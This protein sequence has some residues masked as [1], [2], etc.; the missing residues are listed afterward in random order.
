MQYALLNN[1]RIPATKSKEIAYC[2]CCNSEV[3]AYC[4]DIMVWHWKHVKKEECDSFYEPETKW[5]RDWKNKFSKENQEVV[6]FDE[7]TGEKHV[8]DIKLNNGVVLEFQNSPISL[9]EI[10]SRNDFYKKIIWVLNGDKFKKNF[11]YLN[12]SYLPEDVYWYDWKYANSFSK[13]NSLH[14]GLKFYE[15]QSEHLRMTT[16]VFIDFG[17]DSVFKILSGD[18]GYGTVKRFS[19][20]DFIEKYKQHEYISQTQTENV[21]I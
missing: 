21:T 7:I 18:S 10:K 2:S 11:N 12:Y 3:R 4:G 19:K 8:A 15:R 13:L 14:N 17:G 1:E 5:H 9:R 6:C 16:H 20:K